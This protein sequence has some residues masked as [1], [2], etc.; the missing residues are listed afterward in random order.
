MYDQSK[1]LAEKQ[2]NIRDVLN[3]STKTTKFE[4]GP[5]STLEIALEKTKPDIFV[6]LHEKF[7]KEQICPED[8]KAWWIVTRVPVCFGWKNGYCKNV[9]VT[10]DG[11]VHNHCKF[12]HERSPYIKVDIVPTEVM[13][14]KMKNR[15]KKLRE[16]G[17][18][19]KKSVFINPF[20]GICYPCNYKKATKPKPIKNSREIFVQNQKQLI[21]DF[22]NISIGSFSN[23]TKFVNEWV[24]EYETP[25]SPIS[26][27]SGRS[28]ASACDDE[29]EL[30]RLD[31]EQIIA[32][33]TNE[34]NCEWTPMT[35]F[36]RST[37][38]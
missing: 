30:D 15:I 27:L 28:W 25:Q 20:T 33:D 8:P 36:Q 34:W 29:D 21:K 18:K 12:R 26:I 5:L 22:E 6:P 19:N 32:E 11:R 31:M 38:A 1:S 4:A 7:V 35:N 13:L 37:T 16:N 3:W 14:K 9:K 17:T 24:N 23:K 10:K 2:N